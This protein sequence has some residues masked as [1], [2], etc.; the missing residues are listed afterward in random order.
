MTNTNIKKYSLIVNGDFNASLICDAEQDG[1]TD[2]FPGIWSIRSQKSAIYFAKQELDRGNEVEV[3]NYNEPRYYAV[4][5]KLIKA[6]GT[7]QPLF[8]EPDLTVPNTVTNGKPNSLASL[9][10]YLKVGTK[11]RIA[12]IEL[13]DRSRDTEVTSVQTNAITTKKGDG[14]S[15]MYF[16]KAIN[17]GFD[18]EGA[19]YYYLRDG[20]MTPS[21][22]VEYLD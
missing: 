16:E 12:S 20:I 21:F 8:K 18:N 4:S 15:W 9:K 14:K 2:Y 6:L 19:T 17:W 1:M 7:N 22:R 13:P 11:I 10:K 3:R 5:N